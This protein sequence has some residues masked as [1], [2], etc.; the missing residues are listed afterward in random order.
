VF[1]LNFLNFN[2]SLFIGKMS[3]MKWLFYSNGKDRKHLTYK[4]AVTALL[5]TIIV[6]FVIMYLCDKYF[7]LDNNKEVNYQFL[8]RNH[9]LVLSVVNKIFCRNFLGYL[10]GNSF[11]SSNSYYRPISNL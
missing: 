3:L 7:G 1:K 5:M 4:H 8:V 11:G 9:N 10:V 2:S 6:D